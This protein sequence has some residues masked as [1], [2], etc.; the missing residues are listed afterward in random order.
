MTPTPKYI[1]AV[2]FLKAHRDVKRGGEFRIRVNRF[3]TPFSV[4]GNE[5]K[6]QCRYRI[7]K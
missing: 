7:L 2:T 6:K 4:T 3:H 5:N 1:N